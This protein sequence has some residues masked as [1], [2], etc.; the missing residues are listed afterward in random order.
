MAVDQYAITTLAA[1]KSYLGISTST[2]DAVLESAIDRASYAIESYLDRYVVQRPIYEWANANGS[3]ALVLRH[4]PVGHVHYVAFGSQACMYVRS[5]VATDISATVTIAELRLTLTRVQAD[6]TETATQIQF[7][8]HKTTTSIVAQINA[9]TGFGATLGVNTTA[10]R[11]NRIAGRDLVNAPLT[12]TFADQAQLDTTV[13]NDRGILYFGRNGYD[14]DDGGSRWPNAPISVFCHYDGG[15][16]TVP[17]DIVHACQLIAA[18]IYNGRK[19]DTGV[20][21]ESFGDY[22]YTLGSGAEMDAEALR[23]LSPFK[24]IR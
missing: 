7:A 23:L 2:D 11:M 4:S 5:T 12:V 6:G 24:R 1:L 10:Q 22:S 17:P 16:E 13:D 9:T 3:N 20:Q 21:S 19:R 18:R 14:P 8:N 15:Y